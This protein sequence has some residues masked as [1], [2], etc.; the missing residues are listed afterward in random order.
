MDHQPNR[1]NNGPASS[2]S[3][4]PDEPSSS[5]NNNGQRVT[6]NLP[7]NAA[8]APRLVLGQRSATSLRT[9]RTYHNQNPSLP[10]S[11]GTSLSSSSSSSPLSPRPAGAAFR[12]TILKAS[13]DHRRCIPHSNGM[14][15]SILETLYDRQCRGV[16]AVAPFCRPW[17]PT[18]KHQQ[19]PPT[20]E[21]ELA[22]TGEEEE[23]HVESPSTVFD[24]VSLHT[25]AP[26]SSF[27]SSRPPQ[28]QSQAPPSSQPPN[29]DDVEEESRMREGSTSSTVVEP[30]TSSSQE[31]P[32]LTKPPLQ[33]P[34]QQPQNLSTL[35]SSSSYREMGPCTIHS[36][37]V[38]YVEYISSVGYHSAFLP[39]LGGNDERDEHGHRP[40]SSRAVSTISI[41]FSPDGQAVAS[42]HGDHS[43]KIA[44]CLTGRLLQSL[45]G[46]PRTPWTVKFHPTRSNLVASGCLGH[47]VRIWNWPERTCLHMV[48]LE[49]AIISLSFHPSGTVLAIA[50]GTRLHFWSV[51][52]LNAEPHNHS[53][54]NQTL[55]G[56]RNGSRPHFSRS[57]S[58]TSATTTQSHTN[59]RSS[60]NPLSSTNT[61]T[62]T[63]VEMDQR[64]MLRC[65]HFPPNGKTLIIGGVN[66]PSA[67]EA[68]RGNR[69]GGTSFYL[70]LWDFQLDLAVKP[71][72]C[73]TSTNHAS[74]LLRSLAQ[75]QPRVYPISNVRTKTTRDE[76]LVCV[77]VVTWIAL[78]SIALCVVVAVWC[79]R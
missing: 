76:R 5:S 28:Q 70:R 75:Q 39:H 53:N 66:P 7:S 79:I 62:T 57:Y 4:P 14:T 30:N 61:S 9:R 58:D 35:S 10:S 27:S 32:K 63:L 46:H 19:L 72:N 73:S 44:S 74:S 65:V 68:R 54:K 11:G 69:P 36:E 47:Q 38:Y 23:R 37:L 67:E 2:T 21:P 16:R 33:A 41:A 48:R 64:H 77:H 42:T 18:G 59:S 60:S 26:S 78:T 40:V 52:H 13:L 43:V 20:P 45:E 56:R 31:Q 24:T 1:N 17:H 55:Q 15:R 51:P 50:N 8:A 6:S 3:R 71:P 29:D 22:A 49:F 12:H 34:P 25:N